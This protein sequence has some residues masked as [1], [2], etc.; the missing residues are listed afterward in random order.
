MRLLRHA[1]QG[2]PCSLLLLLLLLLMLRR[3]LMLLMLLR[4]LLVVPTALAT[5]T[6]G[7]CPTGLNGW[8]LRVLW[9]VAALCC[10]VFGRVRLAL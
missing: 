1:R 5:S 9:I 2:N 7:R 10:H 8:C 3:L 6:A 4:L